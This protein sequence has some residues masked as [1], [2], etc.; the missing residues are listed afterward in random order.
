MKLLVIALFLVDLSVPRY[1]I[2][3]EM[4]SLISSISV[5]NP[6]LNIVLENGH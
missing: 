4:T 1:F 3:D 2:S 6:R 5:R